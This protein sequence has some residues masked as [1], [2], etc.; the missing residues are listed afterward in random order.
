MTE[1][2]HLYRNAWRYEAAPHEEQ[3][4][5]ESQCKALLKQGGLLVRNSYGFDQK[6]ESHFWFVIKDKFEG[7]EELNTRDRNKVRH[8][9]EMFD[10][11]IITHEILKQQGYAITKETFDDYPISDRKMDEKIFA[12]FIEERSGAGFEHWGIFEKGTENMVGYGIIHCWEACCELGA[13]GIMT[14]YKRNA[15]YPY[16]GLYHFWNQHYLQERQ[17]KY[18]SDG[19]RTITEHSNI[20]DFLEQHFGYR[21]AYCQLA[22]H[23]Q[24][25]MRMAVRVLYPFR[26]IITFPR[27]KAILNME[28]MQRGEK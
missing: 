8:A 3:P 5:E 1:H 24:W 14:A 16:Y 18:I 17:F 22:I 9:F 10:Y 25:W 27:I 13:T 23:Y 26:K 11:R 6:E 20:Q 4:L 15:S 28:S 19:A 12:Q 21:K 2:Y 7:L